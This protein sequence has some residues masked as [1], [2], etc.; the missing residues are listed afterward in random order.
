[1]EILLIND[2]APAVPVSEA[3]SRLAALIGQR[4]EAKA[5]MAAAQGSIAKLVATQSLAAPFE[6]QL[7]QLGEAESQALRSWSADEGDEAPPAP[8]VEGR[9]ALN[10]RIAEARS[11]ADAARRAVPSLEAEYLR[12]SNR[13]ASISHAVSAAI[14]EI[15]L[16][17]I[18]PGFA[19]I[20][21]IKA[22]LS[23]RIARAEVGRD[24]ALKAVEAIPTDRRLAIASAFY[25]AL[26]A[27]EKVRVLAMSNPPPVYE[28]GAAWSHLASSLSV[29]ARATVGEG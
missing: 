24:I 8:N 1:V 9:E 18:E 16:A 11:T 3:R 14:G 7:A 17:E 4:D 20:V 15:L 27:V 29:D 22:D 23:A 2:D 6:A 28:N 26:G 13:A 19:E 5:E 25:P 12:A 10:R 21:A